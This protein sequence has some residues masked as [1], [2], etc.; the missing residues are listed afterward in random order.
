MRN[1]LAA[2]ACVLAFASSV[3]MTGCKPT[4]PSTFLSESEMEDILYDYHL[5]EAMARVQP[6]NYDANLI[7]YRAAVLKKYDVTQ[8]RFDTSMVYYMRHTALLYAIYKRISDRMEEQAQSYGS[9]TNSL[10]GLGRISA[11]GDTVDIWKGPGTVTLIPNQPYNVHSFSIKPDT[12]FRRGDSYILTMFSDFIFQDGVR[13]GIASLVLVMNND[14][15]VSRV[16][17]IS[18]TTRMSIS[19]D[20]RDSLGV[21]EI[22]G[23]FMLNVNNQ[24]NASASTLHLMALSNIH[25]YKCHP[26]RVLGSPKPVTAPMSEDTSQHPGQRLGNV[27]DMPVQADTSRDIRRMR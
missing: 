23:F 25:L 10:A 3:L 27:A 7:A 2:L 1:L 11:N 22:K 19:I 18:S 6:D 17:H 16:L 4:V 21:K 5:A 24:S 14:S 13:D 12:T 26:R 9:S 15:V 20:D 8:A